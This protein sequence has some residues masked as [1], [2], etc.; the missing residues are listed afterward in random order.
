[1]EHKIGNQMIKTEVR[2]QRKQTP[3][4][5]VTARITTSYANSETKAEGALETI[6]MNTDGSQAYCVL[7]VVDN[8]LQLL[9][10]GGQ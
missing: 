7:S 9:A 5:I 1:M 10:N 4:F 8:A 6:Y 2:V 3:V